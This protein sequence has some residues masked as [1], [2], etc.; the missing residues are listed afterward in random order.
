MMQ[1]KFII[2]YF[3]YGKPAIERDYSQKKKDGEYPIKLFKERD[4]AESYLLMNRYERAFIA[5]T[6]TEAITQHASKEMK[7][8][9]AD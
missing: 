8:D 2:I 6:I 7:I 3:E 5:V 1:S 4:D 9:R